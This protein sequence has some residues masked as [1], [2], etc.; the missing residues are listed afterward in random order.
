MSLNEM[1]ES[2]FPVL[3][4]EFRVVDTEARTVTGKAAP[5][6]T[7]TPIGGSYFESLAPSVFE[8]SI[9]ERGDRVPLMLHHQHRAMPIGKAV[10]WDSQP[11]GVY[12]TWEIAPTDD[13][14]EA[15]RM[16]RDGFLTGLSVGFRPVKN[17][18]D[19]SGEVMKVRRVEAVLLEVSAVSIAAYEDATITLV[20]SRGQSLERSKEH[21]NREA[22]KRWLES[23]RST[24]A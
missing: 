23:V 10:E 16:M 20:R 22:Y 17:D 11:D 24:P 2:K 19:T 5:Y 6:D 15:Y 14:D 13:A 3:G 18:I 4:A 7:W 1:A 9:K 21:L 12:A 8:K